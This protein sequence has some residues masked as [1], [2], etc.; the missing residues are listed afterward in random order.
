LAGGTSSLSLGTPGAHDNGN[1]TYTDTLTALVPGTATTVHATIGGSAVTSA[2]PSI[3]AV[4]GN[5][6]TSQSV[7]TVDSATL[8]SGDSTVVHLQAKDSAGINLTVGGLTVVFFDSGGTS[9]GTTGPKTDHATWPYTAVF[10]GLLAGTATTIHATINGV[11]V[12][13][14]LPSVTVTPGGA[15]PATSVVTAPIDSVASG[16]S[17]LFTIQLKDAAGNPLT[18]AGGASVVFST[19][20]GT[21]TGTIAPSP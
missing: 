5:L 4:I 18:T 12:S 9:T 7:V 15:S 11:T 13:S 20:F 2:L 6:I 14:S 16:G 21:S 19:T 3:T 1:G 17:V 10:H 8:A